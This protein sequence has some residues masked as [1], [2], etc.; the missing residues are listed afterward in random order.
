MALWPASSRPTSTVIGPSSSG[1]FAW[2]WVGAYTGL[3]FPGHPIH[4]IVSC[5]RL[6]CQN[7]CCSSVSSPR[8]WGDEDEISR[9]TALYLLCYLK[10][11]RTGP[12]DMPT[13]TQLPAPFLIHPRFNRDQHALPPHPVPSNSSQVVSA[14]AGTK[15]NCLLSVPPQTPERDGARPQ[16]CHAQFSTIAVGSPTEPLACQA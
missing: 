7:N 1:G 14:P 16:E 4:Y 15:L 13:P 10:C 9:S 11:T 8:T 3:A 6:L 12:A 5:G 2:R